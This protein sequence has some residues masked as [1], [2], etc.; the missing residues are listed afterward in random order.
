M[1]LLIGAEFIA[2]VEPKRSRFR[3]GTAVQAVS[4]RSEG[5]RHSARAWTAPV[6]W[7]F[8]PGSSGTAR[9]RLAAHQTEEQNRHDLEYSNLDQFNTLAGTPLPGHGNSATA[10][11]IIRAFGDAG[12]WKSAANKP[13]LPTRDPL[14]ISSAGDA[15]E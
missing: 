12:S 5:A 3:I 10:R 4:R 8:G 1:A 7:R 2:I 11:R 14:P 15:E 13:A 9:D 6:L